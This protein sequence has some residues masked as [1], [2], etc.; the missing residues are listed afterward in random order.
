MEIKNII[1]KKKKDL[2]KDFLILNMKLSLQ[3][4]KT[5]C[6]QTC[7]IISKQ[8]KELGYSIKVLTGIYFNYPKKIKHSWIECEDKIKFNHRYKNGN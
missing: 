2:E 7:K 4:I 8:L 5:D 6:H 3:G 1:N